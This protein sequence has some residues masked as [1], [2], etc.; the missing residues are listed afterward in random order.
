[1]KML[2]KDIGIVLFIFFS[3]AISSDMQDIMDVMNKYNKSF[4]D[5]NYSEIISC[6]NY[7]TSF[8]LHDN[9]IMA[10]N[11]FKLKLIYKKLRGALPDYYSYSK[12]DSINIELLDDRIA[13]VSARFSRYKNDNSVFYSGAGKYNLRFKNGE[14]KIFS[15]TPYINIKNLDE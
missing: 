7:P 11:R 3:L 9:T 10:N 5:A 6:F 15:I 4:G 8:N 13:V 2:L 14:W 1:M 12:W